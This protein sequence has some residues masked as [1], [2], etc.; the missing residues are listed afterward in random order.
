MDRRITPEQQ[1]QLAAVPGAPPLRELVSHVLDRLDPDPLAGI[2]RAAVL[3]E[4]V[5]PLAGNP[6][7]CEVLLNVRQ[8][9]EITV[10][11]LTADAASL[12]LP[13]FLIQPCWW[14]ALHLKRKLAPN[15]FSR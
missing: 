11:V 8:T 9:Q 15:R 3:D 10:D 4:A 13:G 5:A 12:P 6:A 7:L 14:R 2:D 1:T